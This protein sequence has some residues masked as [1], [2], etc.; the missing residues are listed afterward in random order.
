M[1]EQS[2]NLNS[3]D[4]GGEPQGSGNGRP[5]NPLEGR[6]KQAYEYGPGTS[7]TKQTGEIPDTV[8]DLRR[9]VEER[10]ALESEQCDGVSEMCPL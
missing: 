10:H 3:T 1:L 2:Y 5:R 8:I 7:L 4:E 6:G 9:R